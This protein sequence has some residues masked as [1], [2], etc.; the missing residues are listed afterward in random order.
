MENKTNPSV[1]QIFEALRAIGVSPMLF[2]ESDGNL[3][4]S[5][6]LRYPEVFPL[7]KEGTSYV[8]CDDVPLESIPNDVGEE[9]V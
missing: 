1:N 9:H 7:N 4:I 5:L 2:E 8:A 3:S 6:G